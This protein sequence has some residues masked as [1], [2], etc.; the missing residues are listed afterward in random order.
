M[1]QERQWSRR[2]LTVEAML[3]LG[4]VG[5][6]RRVLPIAFLRSALGKGS[7][8]KTR[9]PIGGHEVEPQLSTRAEKVR[10]VTRGIGRA[11]WRLKGWGNCLD[12][13]LGASLMLRRRRVPHDVVIGLAKGNA[14]SGPTSKWDGHAWVVFDGLPVVGGAEAENYLPTVVFEFRPRSELMAS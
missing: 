10:R 13:A 3:L 4:I 12:Q 5:M 1:L 2:V 7:A 6:A 11:N 14:P 8:P 9:E